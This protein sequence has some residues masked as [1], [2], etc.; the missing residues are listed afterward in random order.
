MVWLGFANEYGAHRPIFYPEGVF[1]EG[2]LKLCDGS[3]KLGLRGRYNLS[4][5]LTDTI[6][7]AEKVVHTIMLQSVQKS[8][9]GCFW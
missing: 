6:F 3:P 8:D 5:E 2:V 1:T 9:I 4:A 7:E